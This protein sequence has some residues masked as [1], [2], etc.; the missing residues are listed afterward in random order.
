[1]S[2]IKNSVCPL[3]DQ[4]QCQATHSMKMDFHT[5]KLAERYTTFVFNS[6]VQPE[7]GQFIEQLI[8]PVAVA[9]IPAR[10][11]SKKSVILAVAI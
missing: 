8:L 10:G 1:M 7:A 9:F 2:L 3:I 4:R 6:S 5:T 11:Q